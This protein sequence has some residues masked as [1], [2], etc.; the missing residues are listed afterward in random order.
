M[1][2]ICVGL[3][4]VR[5]C[6]AGPLGPAPRHAQSSFSMCEAY[7]CARARLCGWVRLLVSLLYILR[8]AKAESP[9]LTQI[10]I[11][12]H[13]N[14]HRKI[15]LPNLMMEYVVGICIFITFALCVREGERRRICIEFLE[16]E[17]GQ[18]NMESATKMKFSRVFIPSLALDCCNIH[19][20]QHSRSDGT[21]YE[22]WQARVALKIEAR[23]EK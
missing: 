9:F 3:E 10:Y 5:V 23:K 16:M 4:L 21:D 12:T 1:E 19:D 17:H 22:A 15:V 13:S 20:C 18:R 14:A 2:I 11:H 7:E 6:V 8:D